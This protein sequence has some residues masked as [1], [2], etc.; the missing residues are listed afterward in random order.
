MIKLT[1]WE[2]RRKD[3]IKIFKSKGLKKSIELYVTSG[4]NLM[5]AYHFIWEETQDES[6]K[7]I[8]D[9]LLEWY[10]EELV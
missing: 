2:P 7:E 9:R 8:R 1:D 5:I 3:I 6:V 10:G 4:I